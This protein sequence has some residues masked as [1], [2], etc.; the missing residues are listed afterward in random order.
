MLPD[1]Q[2]LLRAA[3]G[4][5]TRSPPE[6][7]VG[8]DPPVLA[9][10]VTSREYGQPTVVVQ[11]FDSDGDL[12]VFVMKNNRQPG[13]TSYPG[14]LGFMYDSD[15]T[16]SHELYTNVRPCS[17]LGFNPYDQYLSFAHRLQSVLVVAL[18]DLRLI[19]RTVPAF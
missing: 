19:Y 1:L 17:Q 18:K 4:T 10:P 13:R 15:A 2:I 6:G 8:G 16:V 9:P 3:D 12:D 7:S 5:F 14:E 11:D